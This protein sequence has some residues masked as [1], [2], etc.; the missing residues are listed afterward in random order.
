MLARCL[1]VRSRLCSRAAGPQTSL[2]ASHSLSTASILPSSIL[3]RTSLFADSPLQSFAPQLPSI[4][5]PFKVGLHY[6]RA[7]L[8]RHGEIGLPKGDRALS[9]GGSVFDVSARA[10]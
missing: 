4:P 5:A 3:N 7:P 9:I 10:S 1:R 6:C 8:A 2:F